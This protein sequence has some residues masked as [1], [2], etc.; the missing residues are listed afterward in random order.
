[1]PRISFPHEHEPELVDPEL[2]DSSEQQFEDSLVSSPATEYRSIQL[3]PDRDLQNETPESV[4]HSPASPVS[5]AEA[6]G[7]HLA[8]SRVHEK[9]HAHTGIERHAV[10]ELS[11]DQQSG[12]WRDEIASRLS[13]YAKRRGRKRLAGDYSMQLD[14]DRPRRSSA[15]TAQALEPIFDESVPQATARAI[16]PEAP[17][18]H[19]EPEQDWRPSMA[20]SEIASSL[21][22]PVGGHTEPEPVHAPERPK[23]RTQHRVIE[24]PRLFPLERAENSSDEL[25]EAINKPRI[26][27]VPEETDQIILPLADISLEMQQQAEEAAPVRDFEVP[28]QVAGIS[29]RV[30][31]GLADTTLVLFATATFA[32]IVL[33]L[34]KDMPHNKLTLMAGL[35]IPGVLWAVYQYLFL[36]HSATT[37]GMKIAQLRLATFNGEPTTRQIRR[38]RALGLVLSFVSAG[39]GFGWALV[40]EDTLCWHDRI[41]RTYLTNRQRTSI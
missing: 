40:D 38:T 6:S 33:N 31:A 5:D 27:D 4:E 2:C 10:E 26:L 1:V 15:A 11:L 20:T 25:A 32:G 13:N 14:F 35:A 41:S 37:P 23:R 9:H 39:M 7:E 8:E 21:D 22:V 30:F 36:V 28:I 19:A 16:E 29:Q 24:F 18:G 17:S 34:A 12:N 3:G